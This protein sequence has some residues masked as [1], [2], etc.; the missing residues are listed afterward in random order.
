MKKYTLAIENPCNANLQEM[1]KTNTGFFC[2]LCNKDVIDLSELSNY[3]ISKFISHNKNASICARMKTSQLEEEFSL[4]EQTKV[5][6][7]L[8][9]AAVA[10][11]ILAVSSLQAQENTTNQNTQIEQI[12]KLGK[13]A[14]NP[15]KQVKKELSFIFSGKILDKNSNKPLSI[16]DF[17]E[18]KINVLYGETINYDSKTG[19]FSIKM[20][21][22]KNTKTLDVSLYNQ[23]SNWYKQ[24]PFSAEAVKK[25][26]YIQNIIV[27]PKEF[28]KINIA[29][30]IGINY[31]NKK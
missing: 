31:L 2:S 3:E 18:L 12:E 13:I 6:S 20:I 19:I 26:K 1:Q 23:D 11:S 10:A 22:P 16:K 15:P 14:F 5:N 24:I 7:S 21:V 25:G 27:N 17:K 8:K 30:G 28:Q 9:Y 4:I 29:G